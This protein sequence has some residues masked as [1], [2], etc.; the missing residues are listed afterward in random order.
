MIEHEILEVAVSLA[1]EKAYFKIKFGCHMV[2][3]T[4]MEKSVFHA[5]AE[6]S[7]S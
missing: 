6:F 2:W 4:Q 1:G 5:S 3:G 7:D